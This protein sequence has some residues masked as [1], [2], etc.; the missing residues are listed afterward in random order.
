MVKIHDS[1]HIFAIACCFDVFLSILKRHLKEIGQFVNS[2]WKSIELWQ[3]FILNLQTLILFFVIAI[4][5]PMNSDD[6]HLGIISICSIQTLQKLV[7]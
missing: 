6:V 3:S 5:I 7:I 2:I 4:N 1:K